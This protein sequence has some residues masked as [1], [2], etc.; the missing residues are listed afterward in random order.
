[1]KINKKKD[2]HFALLFSTTYK[3]NK[4]KIQI[5]LAFYTENM[6]TGKLEYIL[7]EEWLRPYLKK[8]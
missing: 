5:F 7:A 3:K 2:I 4:N 6:N 8:F 1:M